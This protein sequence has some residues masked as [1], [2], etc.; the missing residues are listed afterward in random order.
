[1]KPG[2]FVYLVN[3]T[4]DAIQQFRRSL[5]LL[6]TNY[7]KAHPAP[8]I[9]FC[10]SQ[11]SRRV[12]ESIAERHDCRFV[13]IKFHVPPWVDPKRPGPGRI[14]YMHMCRFFANEVFHHPALASFEYYC[15]LDTD[16]FILSPVKVDLFARAKAEN[17]GYGFID[18]TIKDSARFTAGLWPLASRFLDEHPRITP[19]ARPYT[20][21]PEGQVYYTNFEI[22]ECGWFRR[23]PWASFF[24]T[25][26]LNGG[27]YSHRWGDHSVRCL[28]VRMFMPPE[29][30]HLVT[31]VHYRHTFTYNAPEESRLEAA[32]RLVRGRKD[33]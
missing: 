15:R 26:D 24:D 28:G 6:W 12:R 11:M 25:V 19:F 7:R 18:D 22:C 10:E 13:E 14:G 9:A 16:S 33:A 4:E 3:H 1:M 31:D 23:A 32:V 21:I 8:V 29:R 30:I 20:D 2:C 17:W 5:G 27:I